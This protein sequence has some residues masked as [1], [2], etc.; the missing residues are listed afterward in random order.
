MVNSTEPVNS[1]ITGQ[2]FRNNNFK[3]E[4]FPILE[5]QGQRHDISQNPTH[6]KQLS[7]LVESESC[8]NTLQ[9]EFL[10]LIESLC[11]NNLPNVSVIQIR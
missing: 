3:A 10:Q 1:I 11:L 8:A 4:Y 2:S 7:K 6:C 5:E 9:S